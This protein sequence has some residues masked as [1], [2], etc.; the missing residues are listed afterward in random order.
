MHYY[1]VG[2]RN[3]Y[4][5]KMLKVKDQTV[6]NCK[7]SK[8]CCICRCV[9]KIKQGEGRNIA[10]LVADEVTIYISANTVVPSVQEEVTHFI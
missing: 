4:M 6:N 5:F 10:M 3:R 1:A 8:N 9:L 7:H 2:I